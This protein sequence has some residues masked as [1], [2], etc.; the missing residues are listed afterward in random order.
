M[1]KENLGKL[2]DQCPLQL[3]ALCAL[4]SK[5]RREENRGE[6]RLDKVGMRPVTDVR[7]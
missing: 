3:L 1:E 2:L 5:R 4:C 6:K 7:A